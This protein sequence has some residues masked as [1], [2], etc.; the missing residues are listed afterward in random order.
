MLKDLL[1]RMTLDSICKLGFG[2][3]IGT[4][5]PD[6]PENSFAKAFDAANL[7]LT[8]RFFDPF[9]KI[10][11]FFKIGS[12]SQLKKCVEVIDD[13]TYSIIRRQK[14]E[15]HSSNNMNNDKIKVN[16]LINN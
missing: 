13:F 8:R 6:L 15:I 12:E 7:I 9:W 10:R 11:K 2:V 4:L 5:S 1:M 16:I 14:S 3:E